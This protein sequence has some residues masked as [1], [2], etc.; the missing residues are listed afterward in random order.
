MKFSEDLI[1]KYISIVL[2]NGLEP[3]KQQTI[4]KW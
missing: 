4:N 1:E 2:G 3:I